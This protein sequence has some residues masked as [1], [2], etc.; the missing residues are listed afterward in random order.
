MSIRCSLPTALLPATDALQLEGVAIGPDQITTTLVAIQPVGCCL[1]CGGL[2]RRIHSHYPRT[3]TDLP[4][5]ARRVRLELT[6][7]K[8][9]CDD[10]A[11]VRR[12]FTERLPDVVAP[13]ARR[14]TRL[15][16]LLRLLACALEGALG[17]RVLA[18]LRTPASAATLLRLIRRTP[19]AAQPTPRVLG[20]DIVANVLPLLPTPPRSSPQYGPR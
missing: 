7:R 4:W 19:L 1:L 3:L 9:F 15:A 10:P 11:C 17:S 5:G 13:S 20:V 12:I 18:R 8:F 2:S 6:V 14:T 16:D